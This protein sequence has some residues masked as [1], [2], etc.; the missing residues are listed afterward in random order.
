[1]FADK[2]REEHKEM[3]IKDEIE[4]MKRNKKKT[5]K[6]ALGSPSRDLKSNQLDVLNTENSISMISAQ[7]IVKKLGNINMINYT[8][9]NRDEPNDS[10]YNQKLDDINNQR[11]ELEKEE[12]EAIKQEKELELIIKEKFKINYMDEEEK[13]VSSSDDS[14]DNS[15]KHKPKGIVAIDAKKEKLEV[16]EQAIMTDF[17][18]PKNV[19]IIKNSNNESKKINYWLI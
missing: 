16:K 2:L 17:S 5:N 18:Q 8:D 14:P 10:F 12:E 7:R 9:G 3:N 1:M 13:D 6:N 19:E 11:K 15:P 4:M